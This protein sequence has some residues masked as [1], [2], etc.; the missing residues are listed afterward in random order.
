MKEESLTAKA[1]GPVILRIFLGL[2][3]LFDVFA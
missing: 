3:C 1:E 2:L